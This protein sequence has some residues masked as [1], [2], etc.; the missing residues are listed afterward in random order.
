LGAL[1]V[2]GKGQLNRAGG[3]LRHLLDRAR[4]LG[5]NSLNGTG[6]LGIKLL[7]RGELADRNHASIVVQLALYNT[8]LRQEGKKGGRGVTRG[9]RERKKGEEWEGGLEWCDSYVRVCVCSEAPKEGAVVV[10]VQ[11]ANAD[12]PVPTLMRRMRTRHAS[13]YSRASG[14]PRADML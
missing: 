6:D 11:E 10:Q 8:G 4:E 14:Q 9:R 12:V 13:E 5:R 1:G 7:L 3:F 2:G